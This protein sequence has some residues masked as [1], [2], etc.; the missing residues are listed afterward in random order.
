MR[1]PTRVCFFVLAMAGLIFGSVNAAGD[2]QLGEYIVVPAELNT[3]AVQ[4][5]EGRIKRADSRGVRTIVFEIQGGS[6]GVGLYLDLA[7]KITSLNAIQTVAFVRKPLGSHATLV[8]LACDEMVMTPEATLGVV[9]PGGQAIPEGDPIDAAYKKVIKDT[10]HQAQG[11]LIMAMLNPAMAVVEIRRAGGGKEYYVAGTE[12]ARRTGDQMRTVVEPNQ[13]AVYTA[14]Q[15]RD[16]ELCE[17]VQ[18]RAT[19][20]LQHY[21]L[22]PAIMVTGRSESEQRKAALVVIEG[23]ITAKL[24]DHVADQVNAALS[25]EYNMLVF[26]IDSPGGD[27]FA[28]ERIMNLILDLARVHNVHTVAFV[29]GAGALSAAAMIALACQE[30]AIRPNAQLGDA[31][32]LVVD[33]TGVHHAPEKMV[34]KWRDKFR[35]LA[36]I[37]GRSTVLLES[38]VA[39]DSE[40]LELTAADGTR[41]YMFREQYN[42]LP[43]EERDRF[44]VEVAKKKGDFL[45][46]SGERA[47]Q[48][49]LADFTVESREEVLTIYGLDSADVPVLRPS[50]GRLVADF[51]SQWYMRLILMWVAFISLHA[52]LTM[53][54]FGFGGVLAIIC[55]GLFFWTMSWSDSHIVLEM[56]LLGVGLLLIAL[57][58]FVVPGFGVTGVTGIICVVFSLSLIGHDFA[59]PTNAVQ[60]AAFGKSVLLVLASLTASIIGMVILSRFIPSTPIFRRL[61]LA[62]P[63]VKS[64]QADASPQKDVGLQVGEVGTALTVLRPAGKAS[65]GT[66]LVDVTAESVFIEVGKPIEVLEVRGNRIVVKEKQVGA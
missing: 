36:E 38:M 22:D 4:R 8:A 58:V 62:A 42:K 43:A 16:Y 5:I 19:E 32:L 13:A 60:F 50:W 31:G 15:A 18:T 29:K 30:V 33:E 21:D 55:F 10:G 28:G 54:G 24:A 12:P 44:A 14:D 64:A 53:P 37:N 3:A 35:S 47:Q 6:A 66:Q 59:V 56:I 46:V 26:E 2:R 34:S 49:G 65:F 17:R 9:G 52:E 1:L 20:V 48:M 11:P 61:A 23:E 45:T 63:Q 39:K 51:L 7:G 57:E 41:R 40:V 25:D 27:A